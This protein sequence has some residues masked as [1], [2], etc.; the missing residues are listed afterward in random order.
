MDLKDE[1]LATTG[2]CVRT[3]EEV[4]M[5]TFSQDEADVA[6]ARHNCLSAYK[7]Y[8]VVVAGSEV[9]RW[10]QEEDKRFEDTFGYM[11]L[12]VNTDFA[13]SVDALLYEIT[14]SL[15]VKTA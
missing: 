13:Y 3:D 9:A 4:I 6:M 15:G 5:M 10:Q 14:K 1:L 8:T 2:L 7:A 11:P 12:F